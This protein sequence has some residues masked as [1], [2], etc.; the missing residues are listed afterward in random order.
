MVLIEDLD[1]YSR[2]MYANNLFGVS[3]LYWI[4]ANHF[5]PA[6]TCVL[7][8]VMVVTGKIGRLNTKFE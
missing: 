5:A 4:L 7:K 3:S 1:D 2:L 6:P 8:Y